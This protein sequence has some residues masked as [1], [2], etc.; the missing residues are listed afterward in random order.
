PGCAGGS[1]VFGINPEVSVKVTRQNL[2][3]FFARIWGSTSATVAASATAEAYNPSKSGSVGAH[4]LVPVQPRCVKPWII[5]NNDPVLGGT[6]VSTIDGS[7][8]H[9]GV[10]QLGGGVIGE[11]FVL[12][13]A[14]KQGQPSCD[15][16]VGNGIN[17]NAP[18]AGQYVP[19]QVTGTP[20]ATNANA[21]NSACSNA[22][23]FEQAIDG[24][25]QQT[26]YNCGLSNPGM[27]ID[28]D[29][30]PVSPTYATGESNTAA[31]CL[32][33]YGPGGQDSLQTS[34][35]PFQIWAGTNNPLVKA[36]I[37]ANDNPI[38]TSN[39][40]VSIPIYDST[41]VILVNNHQQVTIVGFLQA[42]ITDF[43]PN[44]N[45]NLTVLNVSGCSNNAANAG[46]NGTS[47]VPIRLVSQ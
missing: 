35:Y 36:T 18:G 32:V 16:P 13:S 19:A 27:N 17:T 2:P 29:I 30:A 41:G 5:P 26:Q 12:Q 9:A 11:S 34:T 42:F 10:A 23:S 4:G 43:D 3:T 20:I 14:C 15:L 1:A 33:N 28:L 7:I 38:T 22:D 21:S 31:Q 8:S 25:D 6:F 46:V 39:S 44:G 47:P 37:V 40:I 24:C 45:P